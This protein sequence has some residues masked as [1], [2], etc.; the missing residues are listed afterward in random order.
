MENGS[1]GI[2]LGD[3]GND[4]SFV[5]AGLDSGTTYYYSA[6]AY[7]DVPNYSGAANAAG[8][9]GM[10]DTPPG[11][12]RSFGAEA[13]DSRVTLSWLNP[14]EGDFRHTAVRY[15]TSGYP[16][17]PLDGTAVENGSDGIFTGAPASEDD[18]IHTGLSNGLTYYYTAF[19]ADT[20][21]NYSNGAS[22]YAVPAD[23]TPPG[24]VT[25]LIAREGD[26]EVTLKW[27]NPPDADLAGVRIMYS[28]ESY[29]AGPTDGLIANPGGTPAPADSFVHTGLE[30][31]TTYYYSVFAMDEV[32]NYSTAAGIE[33]TP[34]DRTP[35]DLTI[36]VFR[37]PYISNYLDIY[38]MSTEA[39]ILD[40]LVVTVDEDEIDME[41]ADSDDHV[42]RGD[43][44][45][46]STGTI[47]IK[48]RGRDLMLNA[49]TAQRQ[50]SSS[51]L[52]A[53]AGGGMRSADGAFGLEIPAGAASR[54]GYVLIWERTP[55][56]DEVLS[57][58]DAGPAPFD[59]SDYAMVEFAYGEAMEDPE[60]LAIVLESGGRTVR[61]D[62]YVDRASARIIAYTLELGAFSLTRDENSVS[63]PAGRGGLVILHNSPNPFKERTEIAYQV[64]GA[65]RLSIEIIAIDGRVV[66]ALYRGGITAGR[67]SISWDGRDDNGVRVASGV[68][69]VRITSS[70][71]VAGR[72]VAV[73]R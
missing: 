18:F 49:G 24:P 38:V 39:L 66:R 29:P 10:D 60:H 58:Y 50:F 20:L 67:H 30:N 48:A 26:G 70:S 63:P 27:A 59:L 57:I 61:L 62:S 44:D 12:V 37:N 21:L 72:K 47:T 64:P 43:Y 42:Y 53:I 52:S 2:F 68:Y 35:P 54:D 1:D 40:S 13:A 4:T 19:T 23:G 17:T 7:D 8:T 71:G 33:A 41:T 31:D 6:F 36:S 69:F 51:F 11:E 56:T 14:G 22:V 65:D 45:V 28:T 34:Y 25:D 9:P 5:H 55:E 16:S 3:P 73:L 46:Y 15:S 32:P